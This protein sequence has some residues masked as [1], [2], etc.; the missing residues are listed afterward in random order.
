MSG[1][2]MKCHTWMKSVK[3]GSVRLLKANGRFVK[4][5]KKGDAM[6]W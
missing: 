1:F 2:H 4:S 3:K 6:D 5:Q